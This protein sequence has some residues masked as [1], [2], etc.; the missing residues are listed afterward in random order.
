MGGERGRM[1]C[2]GNAHPPCDFALAPAL[3]D[4]G[5]TA[6]P[7]TGWHANRSIIIG[8]RV[9]RTCAARTSRSLPHWHD[10][11]RHAMHQAMPIESSARTLA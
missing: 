4:D 9:D 1:I 10:E 7:G 2:S 8:R 5:G 11:D 6:D 3:S